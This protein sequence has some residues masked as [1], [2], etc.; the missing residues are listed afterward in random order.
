MLNP[1]SGPSYFTSKKLA[2]LLME[3]FGVLT[4]SPLSKTPLD[5][6]LFSASVISFFKSLTL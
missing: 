3:I 2:P 1:V 4:P 5:Q 6:A